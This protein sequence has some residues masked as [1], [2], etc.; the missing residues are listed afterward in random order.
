VLETQYLSLGAD[1]L[2]VQP[3]RRVVSRR[4]LGAGVVLALPA[5]ITR[6]ARA[7]R[8]LTFGSIGGWF[9]SAFDGTVLAAFRKTHPEITV[10]YYPLANSFQVLGM[11]RGQRTNPSTDVVLLDPGTAHRATAE[12]LL[13]V[14]DPDTT[15]VL[16][17]LISQAT[18][19]GIAGPAMVL[20]SLSIGYSPAQ[21]AGV[22]RNWHDL[23]DTGFGNRLALQTPP[24]PVAL[25]L[26]AIAGAMF[27]GGD[28]YRAMYVGMTALAQLG[29]RVVDWDPVPDIYIAIS[30]GDAAIGP[31]WNAH[32]QNQALLTPGRF[33]ANIPADASP[34]RATTIHLVKGAPEPDAAR[35][36]IAWLLSP[37]AQRLLT[38]TMFFAPVNAKAD[39]AAASL[40]RAGASP[41]MVAK[42]MD[43]DWV[44][45]DA[46]RDQVAAEWRKR[47]LAGR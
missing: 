6:P 8:S 36:L 47:N 32:G 4:R 44:A 45:V 39:I 34:V 15:P 12:G 13:D 3:I 21:I 22:P 17:D 37:E 14:L 28:L 38:E 19:K 7:A 33:A 11:L 25:A 2:L 10:F 5:V 24:D 18:L 20:D 27:G 46:I 30:V 31:C 23:W 43:L 35:T 1:A 16:K 9:G 29:P 26:T 42:R 40:A 41:A